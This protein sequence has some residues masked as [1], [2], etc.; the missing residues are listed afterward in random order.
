ML[1]THK[2]LSFSSVLQ[3]QSFVPRIMSCMKHLVARLPNL[4]VRTMETVVTH[5]QMTDVPVEFL[6]VEF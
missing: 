5:I 2:I 1:L 6:F 3:N 4:L